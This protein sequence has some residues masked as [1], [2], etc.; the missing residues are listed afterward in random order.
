[1]R[2]GIDA[3]PIGEV[4]NAL[5]AHG[6]SYMTRLFTAQEIEDCGGRDLGPASAESLA[7]RF[8]AKEAT[9]KV[10]RVTDRIPSWREIEVIREQGGWV[11]LRLTGLAS[12]LAEAAGM[13]EFD[14]S[15]THTH[16]LAV[17]VVVAA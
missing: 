12:E 11:S 13:T 4:R 14:V 8:A 6:E 7:V 1:M 9:I 10:L 16:D 2:V 5:S 3:Q 17:A 15:L